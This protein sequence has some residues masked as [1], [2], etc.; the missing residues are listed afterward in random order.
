[1]NFSKGALTGAILLASLSLGLSFADSVNK[2]LEPLVGQ[3]QEWV[4]SYL[5]THL[6]NWIHS[7]GDWAEFTAL[8]LEHF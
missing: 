5:E 2:E 7:S 6:A 4:V 1:M 3:V 8:Y